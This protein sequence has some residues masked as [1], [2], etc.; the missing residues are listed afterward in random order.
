MSA[1]PAD[2]GIATVDIE[3]L[4]AIAASPTGI[5][6]RARI[7]ELRAELDRID[8]ESGAHSILTL[9]FFRA[10][11]PGGEG[12]PRRLEVEAALRALAPD[13]LLWNRGEHARRARDA[14]DAV[15]L[16]DGFAVVVDSRATFYYG[17]GI[18]ITPLVA[19]MLRDALKAPD[20]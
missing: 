9:A 6:S 13:G 10:T 18:D 3:Q 12:P 19:A 8:R 5:D 1:I 14:I 2:T 11:M 20:A 7:A 16:R 4:E 15:A 17:G